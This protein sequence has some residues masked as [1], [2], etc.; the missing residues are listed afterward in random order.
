MYKMHTFIIGTDGK[1]YEDWTQDEV[2]NH[3][4]VEQEKHGFIFKHDFYSR[5]LHKITLDE[6]PERDEIVEWTGKHGFAEWIHDNLCENLEVKPIDV[7]SLIV[8]VF[9]SRDS[10]K[11]CILF[12]VASYIDRYF[13]FSC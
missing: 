4:W 6:T 3:F 1:Y 8:S 2:K 12:N 10:Y 11:K 7:Q 5:V 13:K 9:G